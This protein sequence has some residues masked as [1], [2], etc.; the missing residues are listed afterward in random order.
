MDA[1]TIK[2]EGVEQFRRKLDRMDDSL[3]RSIIKKAVNA[4]AG[5]LV[6]AVRKAAPIGPTGNLKRSVKKRIKKYPS[7]VVVAV[8]GGAWPIGA[9]MHLVE[10]GTDDRYHESGKYVGKMPASHFVRRA[11]IANHRKAETKLREKLTSELERVA[12]G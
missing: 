7:G 5:V 10:E 6:K 4:G 1:V 3:S 12:R 8:M 9:H 11:F 2:L